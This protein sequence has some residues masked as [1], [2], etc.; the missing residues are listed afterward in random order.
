MNVMR[1]VAAAVSMLGF[2]CQA[3]AKLVSF[4]YSGVIEYVDADWAP[5]DVGTP[6]SGTVS[7][8]SDA[9][10]FGGTTTESYY[11]LQGALSVTIG[12]YT[13]TYNE[14]D[15]FVRAGASG[16]DNIFSFSSPFSGGGSPYQW[17][18]QFA[19]YTGS[20][21][22]STGLPDV[23][24]PA[25]SEKEGYTSFGISDGPESARSVGSTAFIAAVP[26]PTTW[27][28]MIIGL[29]FVGLYLRKRASMEGVNPTPQMIS[30]AAA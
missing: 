15:A 20:Y 27:A 30:R 18:I 12:G 17:T 5:F 2:S 8:D 23:A 19:D 7:Y 3:E 9:K 24:P 25:L 1:Y 4:D 11:N 6:F 22:T 10:P 13:Q 29:A 14:F 21:L 16:Q 26:E 28:M